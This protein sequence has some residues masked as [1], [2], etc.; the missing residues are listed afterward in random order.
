MQT[1]FGR[2]FKSRHLHHLASAFGRFFYGAVETFVQPVHVLLDGLLKGMI[3]CYENAKPQTV[4]YS[5]VEM[6]QV[7]MPPSTNAIG[8]VFGGQIMGWID[9]CAAVSAQ[10]HCRSVVV[11]ASFDDVHFL[12]PIKHGQVVILKSQVNAVF[13]S[14]MEIGTNIIVEDPFTGERKLAIRAF[15]TFVA[16]DKNSSKPISCPPLITESEEE[17]KRERDA[18]LRRKWRLEHRKKLEHSMA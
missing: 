12:H 16:L 17:E 4:K 9:I 10:R 1:F 14:S 5:Y 11:T 2:G 13:R 3:M 8:T 18:N 15:S 7:V 6:T